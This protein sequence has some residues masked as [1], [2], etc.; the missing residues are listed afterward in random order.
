MKFSET[1]IDR[2]VFTTVMSLVIVLV[3]LLG[4]V[5]L[6]NREL[7]DI[8]PPKVSVTTV[9]TG[10]SAEVVETSV[11]KPIEDAVNGID[12]VK[13]VTSTSREQ[14]SQITVE[15]TLSRD[16]EAAA[17]DVRDRVARI[18]SKLPDDVTDPVVAK[19]DRDA[20]PII[21]MALYGENTTQIEL[22]RLADDRIVDRLSK[23][24]GV[25]SVIN[26]GERRFSMRIWI[27]N[28]RL[29]SRDLTITELVDKLRREHVDI[30]SGRIESEDAEFT[31]R[32]L[33][34]LKT[35]EEWAALVVATKNG[36]PVHL[37]DV[38]DIETGPESERKLV[39]FRGLPA[40]GL[41][42]V[43]QSKA[44]TLD[45]ADAIHAEVKKLEQELPG[46]VH[47]EIA[48]DSSQFIRQSISDVAR[49]I[50]EAAVLVLL[51]IYV[52]LRSVR[53]TIVPAVAIPVSIIGSLGF[54]YFAGFTIN[55]LTL[56]GVTL[57]IGLVVDD[58]IVVLENITRWVEE[59]TPPLQAARAGMA[60]I[61]FAVIASTISAVAV[62]LPLVFL[63]DTTGK[64]FREFA[65][66]VASAVAISGFV[67]LT[68]SPMMSARVLRE[69]REESGLK[70]AL[71]RGFEAI[72]RGYSSL[73]APLVNNPLASLGLVA[74]GILWA[75]FGGWLY[76]EKLPEELMPTNDRSVIFVITQAPE[77][78]T[79]EYM[80]RYQRMA[81]EKLAALPEIERNF[82][83]IA[84][85]FG[86]PGAVNR[87][88]V[89]SMLVPRDERELSQ[90]DFGKRAKEVVEQVP[91]IKAYIWE[92]SPMRGMSSSP[93]EVVIQGPDLF[94]LARVADEVESQAKEEGFEGMRINLDLNKPQLEVSVDRNRASDLGMSMRD[95]STALQML[96]GGLDITTFK[97][98]GETYN[99]MVQLR[100][101]ERESV[102]DLTELFVRGNG[103]LISLASVVSVQETI[104]PRELPHF[105]RMR[106]VTITGKMPEGMSQGDALQRIYQIAQ[107]KLPL[108]G[109]YRV[110]F[111]GEAE[112]FFESGNA[113]V[114]AYL[115]ALLVVYLVLAAQFESFVYPMAIMVAVLLS[116]TG[117]LIALDWFDMSLNIF[118]K[119]GI[120]MLV[121]LVTKNSILIVEFANQLR[122]RGISLTDATVQA[123]RTRFRPILMTSLATMVGIM[124][125]ALGYGA[126][127]ESRAPLGTAV[128]GGMFFS[129]ILT[130]FVV[131]AT[132][133]TLERARGL[134]KRAPRAAALPV[135]HSPVAGGR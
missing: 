76:A 42:I 8:D 58:A 17:N 88:I 67:A 112:K 108:E 133:V 120:V 124:P 96:L 54:L 74:F 104:A 40:I 100:R 19:Q 81:E 97:Q 82:S 116:F 135:A 75:G 98:D 122:S 132:Y 118:S 16:I 94:E 59:G 128:V 66:T 63:Q 49:T 127:G 56:M 117:A 5:R 103:G 15:F 45:A 77:G 125:I 65:V 33:G 30:P 129:T 91:G 36:E 39:R 27:D 34:E 53:A 12:G 22:T 80:D 111:S 92:P 55:T 25:S 123:A 13:H 105:D 115:L 9:F 86:T 99:V 95:I 71:G 68:L 87:G 4:L 7:P 14:V 38:A 64:L 90:T 79:V 130:Y 70:R 78:S 62:F 28:R 119:I 69:R 106:A 126:G 101:R 50:F 73:L 61:S 89:I 20:S 44:N 41:G 29:A 26:A 72:A 60:E 113:L 35:P 24:P 121:G 10:A 21:W 48:F 31:V 109:D 37:G 110:L 134:L 93:I 52:F 84:L 43:K 114:F 47:F 131:P 57:A 83:I 107:Q 6:S 3:G 85:G 23:L 1:C 46:N 11:T 102:R 51:V 32:S 2:P 18:R